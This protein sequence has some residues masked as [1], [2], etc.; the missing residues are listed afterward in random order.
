MRLGVRQALILFIITS[1]LALWVTPS[2]AQEVG[3][4]R[5]PLYVGY[6]PEELY[7]YETFSEMFGY[8]V[9]M[10]NDTLYIYLDPMALASIPGVV[11]IEPGRPLMVARCSVVLRN[12]YQEI[13]VKKVF[14]NVSKPIEL[15]RFGADEPEGLW[16]LEVAASDFEETVFVFIQGYLLYTQVRLRP[17]IRITDVLLTA[18]KSGPQLTVAGTISG[19]RWSDGGVLGLMPTAPKF[20]YVF[21]EEKALVTIEKGTLLIR[22]DGGAL[23]GLGLRLYVEVPVFV[24]TLGQ[25][26]EKIVLLRHRLKVE[27]RKLGDLLVVRL[28]DIR[29]GPIYLQ[30]LGKEFLTIPIVRV[31]GVWRLIPPDSL[32][33]LPEEVDTH[34]YVTSMPIGPT[35][36]YAPVAILRFRGRQLV[37][38]G[39]VRTLGLAKIRLLN[40]RTGKYVEDYE[41][42]LDPKVPSIVMNG[43][44]Y[45]A[46]NGT[47]RLSLRFVVNGVE[48][49][50]EDIEPAQVEVSPGS[51][52]EVVTEL[53]T[54]DIRVYRMEKPV[55]GGTASVYRLKDGRRSYIGGT[56]ITNST[57]HLSL[58][59]GRYLLRVLV[60]ENSFSYILEVDGDAVENV[61]LSPPNPLLTDLILALGAAG[62]A[63]ELYIGY[64]A[65]KFLR[66]RRPKARGRS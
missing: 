59:K 44:T 38:P 64:R 17:E 22:G 20:K 42:R 56:E 19:F 14:H 31:G 12:P 47:M 39:P 37:Y 41:I 36:G 25:A 18:S 66:A 61:D 2:S 13:V 53:Y 57:I 1:L 4:L 7:S 54:V 16:Y 58:P 29:S 10:P 9:Y 26:Y 34:A 55:P 3:E 45:V 8:P 32:V 35:G 27:A 48:L 52:V 6:S 60:G 63:A 49:G 43:T 51:E 46:L 21:H 28:P 23:S 62:A 33:D 30:I 5:G 50:P 65:A 15:Y 24:S 40:S 11:L